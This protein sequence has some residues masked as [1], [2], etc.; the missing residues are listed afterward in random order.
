MNSL[1]S[2]FLLSLPLFVWV[3]QSNAD[4]KKPFHF[5][6][7]GGAH[8]FEEN[9]F[10]A[11]KS[12][13]EKGIRGYELDVRM[14]SDGE[15]VVLHDDSLDR[16]HQGSGPVE[17]LTAEEAKKIRSKKQNEPLL[18]LDTLL[19]YLKDKPG[20]YVEFEM[21]T[22][23]KDLYSD[24]RI[25]DYVAKLHQAVTAFVPDGSTY[26]FTSFDQRPLKAIKQLDPEADIMLIKGGPLTPELMEAA[27]AIGS[28]RIA[29]KM[30]G[31][32]RLAVQQAQKQ[33]FTVTGWPG[34]N[35]GDYFLG[36]GLGVDAICTD[37][38]VQ[39]QEYIESKK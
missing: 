27:K 31:T 24:S 5:A 20:M 25:Q 39:V 9:T 18:F 15:L 23:N 34:H 26:I 4:E 35:L 38:P 19:D 16:T 32:T 7:R 10:F 13:Y 12:S 17:H 30:E 6:H 21:K 22:S 1:K 3:P 36:L 2:I 29:A 37:V 33:G 28:K 11:F 8:E 14:T